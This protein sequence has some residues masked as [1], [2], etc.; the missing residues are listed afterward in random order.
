[1][2]RKGSGPIYL[3]SDPFGIKPSG[4][5]WKMMWKKNGEKKKINNTIYG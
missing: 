1:M 2:R 3:I 4:R 5:S